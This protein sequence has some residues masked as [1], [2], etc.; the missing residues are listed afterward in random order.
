MNSKSFYKAFGLILSVIF[1]SFIITVFIYGLK[2]G[3]AGKKIKIKYKDIGFCSIFVGGAVENEDFYEIRY[4]T[5]YGELFNLAG[6]LGISN[7]SRFNLDQA[8]NPLIDDWIVCNY[9]SFTNANINMA[10][11]EA[12][13]E[14]GIP[15]EK[16]ANIRNYIYSNGQIKHKYQLVELGLLTEDEFNGVKYKIFAYII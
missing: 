14:C 15:E 7:L 9:G 6:V 1:L 16:A 3:F 12:L 11:I 5:T 10:A 2:I 13:K 8:V 4:S